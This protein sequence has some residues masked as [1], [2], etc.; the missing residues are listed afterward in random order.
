LAYEYCEQAGIGGFNSSTR[1]AGRTWAKNFLKRHKELRKK[2]TIGLS[3][4]RA[5]GAN[6]SVINSW[7]G[8]YKRTL[9]ELGLSNQPSHIWNVDE[10]GMCDVPK[11]SEVIGE[12]GATCHR[13]VGGEKGENSTLV[14][15]INAAGLACPP[16]L[17]HSGSRV[18]A[19]WSDGAPHGVMIRASSSGYINRE[20]FCEYAE[21][22]LRFVRNHKLD[23]SPNI[24]ILDGHKSHIYNMAFL[25]LMMDANWCV[26]C[27]PPHTSHCMQPLDKTPFEVLKNS[28]KEL[29]LQYNFDFCGKKLPKKDF[30][31][32]FWPAWMQMS[33][34]K[35]IISGF[36]R[37]GIFPVCPS[38]I[39]ASDLSPS[40]ATDQERL[41]E[42]CKST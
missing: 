23:K 27:I 40:H 41:K 20:L 35:V 22:F 7:F 24:L 33:R 29:L 19:S 10:S 39:P 5:M 2:K 6:R 15:F 14:T 9:E 37:T 11:E 13:I 26:L 30:F 17:I 3:I 36:N 25:E 4:N 18:Q 8:L 42:F 1:M 31:K 28:W 32:V 34:P 38:A 21:R 12:T 16:M